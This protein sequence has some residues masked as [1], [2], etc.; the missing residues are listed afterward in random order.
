[1]E[2]GCGNWLQNRGRMMAEL[3]TFTRVGCTVV[4]PSEEF[5]CEARLS[6]SFQVEAQGTMPATDLLEVHRMKA[7]R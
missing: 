3:Q 4:R 7:I 2:T 6:S 1:L 5:L